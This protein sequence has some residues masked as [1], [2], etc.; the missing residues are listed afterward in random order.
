MKELIT[1]GNV[2][3][4]AK[5][6]ETRINTISFTLEE[7]VPE[8]VEAAFKDVKS[9]TVGNTDGEVY[10]EY[11]DVEFESITIGADDAVTVTMHIPTKMEKQL[12]DLQETVSSH[13]AAIAEHDEAITAMMFGGELE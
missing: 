12:R 3:Y 11:P 6:V 4:V 8:D 7:S 1:I 5:K 10:G 2:S 9:L 13:G